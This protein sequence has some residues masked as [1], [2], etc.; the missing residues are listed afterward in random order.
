MKVVIL[1]DLLYDVI[2]EAVEF[3]MLKHNIFSRTLNSF[4]NIIVQLKGTLMQ[5]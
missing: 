1:H 5:I 2:N 3:V 4:P